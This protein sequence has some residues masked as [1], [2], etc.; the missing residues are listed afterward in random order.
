[1]KKIVATILLAGLLSGSAVALAGTPTGK[2]AKTTSSAKKHKKHKKHGK[3]TSSS[4][5]T[6]K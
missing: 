4:A 3:K 5:K 6:K 1:M 2:D